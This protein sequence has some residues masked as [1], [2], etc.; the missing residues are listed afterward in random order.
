MHGVHLSAFATQD[1]HLLYNL[2]AFR[3]N[4]NLQWIGATE[5]SENMFQM[6]VLKPKHTQGFQYLLFHDPTSHDTQMPQIGEACKVSFV[7]TNIDD[8]SSDSVNDLNTQLILTEA[9]GL[10]AWSIRDENIWSLY[11]S[12]GQNLDYFI[13]VP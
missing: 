10:A 13:L 7:D 2:C 5:L 11:A 12:L 1:Q 9:L 3:H 6:F 4:D 8:V